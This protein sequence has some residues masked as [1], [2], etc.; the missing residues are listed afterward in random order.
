MQTKEPAE[1]V[2]LPTS[3]QERIKLFQRQHNQLE[4][5]KRMGLPPGE[6]LVISAGNAEGK[7]I[8]SIVDRL[9]KELE[10]AKQRIKELE[11]MLTDERKAHQTTAWCLSLEQCPSKK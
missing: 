5:K 6:M 2:Q 1:V 3:E 7:S 11:Q 8:F 4:M 10:E 9:T